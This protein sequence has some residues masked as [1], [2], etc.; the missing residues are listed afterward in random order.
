MA[1][2]LEGERIK[3]IQ[4]RTLMLAVKTSLKVDVFIMVN[5]CAKQTN[6]IILMLIILV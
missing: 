6:I 1:T 2:E 4:E 5:Y 3:T